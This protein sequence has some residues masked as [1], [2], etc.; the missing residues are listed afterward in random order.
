MTAEQRPY[1]CESQFYKCRDDEFDLNDQLRRGVS[2]VKVVDKKGTTSKCNEC[3]E[4]KL[5]LMNAGRNVEERHAALN[6]LNAHRDKWQAER[7]EYYRL[8][9]SGRNWDIISIAI[10]SKATFKTYYPYITSKYQSGY[11]RS[12]QGQNAI[13]MKLC[14]VVVHGWKTLYFNIPDWID[15]K[16]NGSG[17]AVGTIILATLQKLADARPWETAGREMPKRLNIT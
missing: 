12:W 17:N 2:V 15:S 11:W 6:A 10:D 9:E 4:L 8:R 14:S 1:V 13:D 5:A 3:T 16:D 7:R